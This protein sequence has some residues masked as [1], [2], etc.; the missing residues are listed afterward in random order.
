MQKR[1][2]C[3]LNGYKMYENVRVECKDGLLNCFLLR[4]DEEVAC[5]DSMVDRTEEFILNW[6]G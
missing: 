6:F 4:F 5:I 1:D 2:K 3:S